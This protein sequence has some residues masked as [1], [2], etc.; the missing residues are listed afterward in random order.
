MWCVGKRL[1][2][3]SP[4]SFLSFGGMTQAVSVVT[5]VFGA[6][7]A[8]RA[9]SDVEVCFDLHRDLVAPLLHEA[10]N[11]PEDYEVPWWVAGEAVCVAVGEQ[12][13]LQFCGKDNLTAPV[14]RVYLPPEH[15]GYRPDLLRHLVPASCVEPPS[16]GR[17]APS[18]PLVTMYLVGMMVFRV[19]AM[20]S[21]VVP[22]FLEPVL[23]L[24]V[25]PRHL[26]ARAA[27]HLLYE[28]A[29][30]RGSSSTPVLPRLPAGTTF[31][32]QVAKERS[33]LRAAGGLV[34]PSALWC[35]QEQVL[36]QWFIV[37]NNLPT[38]ECLAFV[39][40]KA[41]AVDI[42]LF[43][44]G[45]RATDQSFAW[46]TKLGVP[47]LTQQNVDIP[48]L[49]LNT[50]LV[51]PYVAAVKFAL[52]KP[53]SLLH[54]DP[55]KR[56]KPAAD[57][58]PAAPPA[59]AATEPFQPP[60]SFK[61][62]PAKR[63]FVFRRPVP[64]A[65]AVGQPALLPEILRERHVVPVPYQAKNSLE[66]AFQAAAVAHPPP[67][68]RKE[69]S[70]P[71]P[72]VP[73][74]PRKRGRED[75]EEEEEDD[76]EEEDEE[77]D[78]EEEEDDAEEE[79][80]DEEE[81]TSSTSSKSLADREPDVMVEEALVTLAGH[82]AQLDQAVEAVRVTAAE[83]APERQEVTTARARQREEALFALRRQKAA[84]A[85]LLRA[86]PLDSTAVMDLARQVLSVQELVLP[87]LVEV[88]YKPVAAHV[89][90]CRWELFG[91]DSGSPRLRQLVV[92]ETRTGFKVELPV[93]GKQLP[94]LSPQE[95]WSD[96]KYPTLPAAASMAI[97]LAP[98][99]SPR[100]KPYDPQR[101]LLEQGQRLTLA[102][103]ASLFGNQRALLDGQPWT[104]KFAAWDPVWRY[105][106]SLGERNGRPTLFQVT[107]NTWSLQTLDLSPAWGPVDKVAV[108]GKRVVCWN[109]AE[110]GPVG[111]LVTMSH[112]LPD[113]DVAAL[114][115]GETVLELRA[116]FLLDKY[117]LVRT[118]TRVLVRQT[119]VPGWP[120]LFSVLVDD[121]KDQVMPVTA[122]LFGVRLARFPAE[123]HVYDCSS[124]EPAASA[125]V[126]P[127]PTDDGFGLDDFYTDRQAEIYTR[128]GTVL[129]QP[130]WL[131]AEEFSP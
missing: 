44:G 115:D 26:R 79:D 103:R 101:A 46:A 28:L 67:A 84:Q 116:L 76:D 91:G 57:A 99:R 49:V 60:A 3:G 22:L 102:G 24:L 81:D 130:L 109:S 64:P 18:A 16:P 127:I 85:D 30:P 87:H 29:W 124:P 70:E 2:A 42:H 33:R 19:L 78:D 123:F 1:Q 90:S 47:H 5:P 34:D 72:T 128:D 50:D 9:L 113:E 59:A 111:H 82:M 97:E 63:I 69:D 71:D 100:E 89:V 119:T 94:D 65:T 95:L 98:A 35:P 43:G 8:L 48:L 118:P 126:V 104:A 12:G 73:L 53:A 77:D 40:H 62:G 131:Q 83:T 27:E 52:S 41:A 56:T 10:L 68:F 129:Y 17:G 14:E 96:A 80:E 6:V 106:Y 112:L 25:G 37:R 36:N 122:R 21:R 75:D 20:L 38:E 105:S 114:G 110:E 93:A 61:T 7:G 88:S 92:Q 39:A 13:A 121:S 107:H 120:A 125:R 51:A 55:M 4:T 117:V 11:P 15:P 66:T 108:V 23:R 31:A 54:Q 32:Q 58:V 86:G 45:R 74:H